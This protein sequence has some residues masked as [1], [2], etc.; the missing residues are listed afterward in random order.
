MDCLDISNLFQLR[1]RAQ[2]FGFWIVLYFSLPHILS[3]V[4][5]FN[6]LFCMHFLLLH[7][8][9]NNAAFMMEYCV[10]H[11]CCIPCINGIDFF[12]KVGGKNNVKKRS[13]RAV[14]LMELLY[15]QAWWSSCLTKNISVRSGTIDKNCRLDVS[16]NKHLHYELTENWSNWSWYGLKK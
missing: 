5:Q 1:S 3:F 7:A 11:V 14:Q 4:V 12:N 15:S 9:C 13:L 16:S 8:L 6:L 2:I 10:K